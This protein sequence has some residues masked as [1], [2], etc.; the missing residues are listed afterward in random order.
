MLGHFHRPDFRR[1]RRA[2][3]ARHHQRRQDGAELAADRDGDDCAG[4]RS[5]SEL[6]EL[7]K[8]LR[9]KNRTGETSGDDDDQLR[10][11]SN[12]DDLIEKQF[13]PQLV[14]KDRHERVGREHDDLAEILE[15]RQKSC[16]QPVE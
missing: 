13:P 1:H 15:K 7:K 8:R 10:Q 16:A 6:V 4:G 3:A 5:H 11:Q 9:G 14:G 2:D 12:F